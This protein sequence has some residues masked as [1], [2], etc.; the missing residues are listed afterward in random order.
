MNRISLKH[1]ILLLTFFIFSACAVNALTLNPLIEAPDG[2]TIINQEP[3]LF[4]EKI[5]FVTEKD[6]GYTLWAYDLTSN[7][8]T[9]LQ[10][11]DNYFSPRFYVLGDYFYL[12][13]SFDPNI[14]WRSDGTA[15]GTTTAGSNIFYTTPL[16]QRGDLIFARGGSLG[17]NLIVMGEQGIAEYINHLNQSTSGNSTVGLAC[18]FSIHDV[19]YS[20]RTTFGQHTLTRIR[21]GNNVD[22]T[23]ELPQGFEL[24]PERVWFYEDTCFFHIDTYIQSGDILVIPKQGD[25]YFLGEQLGFSEVNYLTR[26]KDH[27]YLM[28]EDEDRQNHIVKL[29]LDLSTVVKQVEFDSFAIVSLIVSNDYLIAYTHSGPAASPPAWTTGYFD[30]DLNQISGLGGPFTDVPQIYLRDGGETVVINHHTNGLN[31]KTLT[32][33]ITRELPGLDLN[34]KELISVITDKDETETYAIIK[35]LRSGQSSIKSLDTIPDVGSLSVGN[36]FDPDYQ[37]QGM[38]VV[39]GLRDD[40][41]RYLFVTLYLFRDGEPL[42]LA[43]TSNINYPQPTLDIELGAYSGPGLWQPDTTAQVE[44]F[45]DMTLS[46]SGCHQLMVNFITVDGQTFSLEL[47]RMVNND[48][49]LYCKD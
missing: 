11:F 22:Y 2:H 32:T 48:I 13:D 17:G 14:V 47:Q 12:K 10:E 49:K 8:Y 33:D 7:E 15:D 41:S 36:W 35:D 28:A 45:A 37:S 38:S 25:H 4:N 9:S 3:L 42:W 18:G 34:Q 43:G 1:R 44:K 31:L 19:I 16:V 40:G 20:S 24:W 30:E 26:F 23:P 39:E 5:I 21:P 29:S 27:F 6:E 46:M